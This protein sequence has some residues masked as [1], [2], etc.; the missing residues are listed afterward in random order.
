MEIMEMGA[1]DELVSKWGP[2]VDGIENDYTKRVTAQLLENQLKSAQQQRVDEAAVDT[3][4]TTVG[5]LGTF[6]KF[7]FPL[8]R[9]VFPE[10]IA[11]NIVS[12]QPMSAP[13]SQVFYLG[14]ARVSGTTRETIYSKYNLTYRGLTTG[15]VAGHDATIDLD[16]GTSETS[17]SLGGSALS[18]SQKR[19]LREDLSN[20]IFTGYVHPE[21]VTDMI[22]ALDVGLCPYNISQ[23]AHASS[24]MRLL[25][26]AAASLPTVCTKLE[27][28]R[29]MNFMNVILVDED[30]VSLTRG[31]M[32]AIKMPR[33]QPPQITQYD[34]NR[35]ANQYETVLTG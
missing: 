34:I 18:G 31:I 25:L 14:S 8:V 32:Q 30:P 10:L 23:G 11:N 35:L 2:A 9:R 28:V 1:S 19:A 15:P 6:Q 29:R 33:V 5:S 21:K 12:V 27:E 20:V 24:P 17:Q 22:S 26:Y 16:A 7:A 4:T 13:V 3:G